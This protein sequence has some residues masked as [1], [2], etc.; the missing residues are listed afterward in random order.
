MDGC[1]T[2]SGAYNGVCSY[3]EQSCGHL[4]YIHCR[5]HRL[6][7]CFAHLLPRYEEF[8]E[9]D[10]LLLNLYLIMK[11]SNVKTA[12]FEEVQEAYDLKSLKLIKGVV[13]RWLSHGKAVE[14]V[15]DR[16]E[17][18]VTALEAI[19]L[20]KKEPAVKYVFKESKYT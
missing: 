11:H 8:K 3:F 15:L 7:L 10:A 14:C 12:I 6:A 1:S 17:T 2:M 19:Y 18:L 9:F 5:N 13:T 16:Y 4:V 20:R